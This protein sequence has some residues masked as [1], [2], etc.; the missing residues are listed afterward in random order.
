MNRR[1]ND[2]TGYDKLVTTAHAMGGD[3][4]LDVVFNRERGEFDVAVLEPRDL[5]FYASGRTRDDAIRRLVVAMMETLDHLR[6]NEHR[7]APRQTRR[8]RILRSLFES[9]TRE[10]RAFGTS[11]QQ[12]AFGTSDTQRLVGT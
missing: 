9:E 7:L 5:N 12:M 2:S 11:S 3:L 6:A 1:V 4:L 8:L 10:R